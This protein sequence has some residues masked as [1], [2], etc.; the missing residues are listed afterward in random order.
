MA[1]G[2][3]INKTEMSKQF[4]HQLDVKKG[5]IVVLT[6]IST[7]DSWHASRHELL[8]QEFRVKQQP[9]RASKDGQYNYSN[10]MYLYC[11]AIPN[12]PEPHPEGDF[13]FSRC[14]FKRVKKR[15]RML[16]DQMTKREIILDKINSEIN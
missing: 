12:Q 3:T 15:S 2:N 4:K 9:K 1:H 5:D 13:I 8:F 14:Q 7:T 6:A 16:P 11:T 10:W